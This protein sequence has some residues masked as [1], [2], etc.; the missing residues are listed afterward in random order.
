MN[1]D[2]TFS[3]SYEDQFYG[4]L[5]LDIFTLIIT[6]IIIIIYIYKHKTIAGP[7]FNYSRCIIN[8]LLSVGFMALFLCVFF[9]T[10]MQTLEKMFIKNNIRG[11]IKFL[12]VN[13]N[14]TPFMATLK[15]EVKQYNDEYNTDYNYTNTIADDNN[16]IMGFA[17][18]IAISV[19]VTTFFFSMG[20]GYYY[21]YNLL[22]V[23]GYNIFMLITI[24]I[25]EIIYAGVILPNFILIDGNNILY[26]LIADYASRFRNMNI[27]YL[28]Y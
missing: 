10:Y 25:G 2:G 18:M 22:K 8:L 28:H 7:R 27:P 1:S 26:E 6:I 9:F 14:I 12:M 16:T 19:C 5:S 21:G 17:Y 4:L 24:I 20:I 15:P 11:I 3:S 13:K 23:I